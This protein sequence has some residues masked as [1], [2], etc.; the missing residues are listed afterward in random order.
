MA[1]DIQRSLTIATSIKEA[2]E[3][4]FKVGA[5]STYLAGG[6]EV[7]RLNSLV[8]ATDL[9]SIGRIPELDGILKDGDSIKI[10]AMST[11]QDIIDSPLTPC[12]LKQ[13]CYFMASRTK[14]NM[15]T[16]GGNLAISRTDSYLCPSLL[17]CGAKLEL[18]N[19]KGEVVTRCLRCYLNHKEEYQNHLILS[20][21]VPA[22]S[23]VV[24]KR[25]SNTAQSHA[26]LT[27][28]LGCVTCNCCKDHQEN[29]SGCNLDAEAHTISATSSTPTS[30][31]LILAVAAKNTALTT[32]DDI[33]DAIT[34]AM[35][36]KKELSDNEILKMVKTNEKLD[37]KEDI[38][39]SPEY[40]AYLLSVT[41]ADL[42]KTLADANDQACKGIGGAK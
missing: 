20:I 34:Q 27:V 24:S 14:R 28:S 6:T 2:A 30:C 19:E 21:T 5:S 12:Y 3:L 25:F 11:F 15:A 36:N 4:K 42:S 13:A 41:I 10:G 40:K 22:N 37:F 1:K 35:E 18:M 31:K 39:G 9:I 7:N 23:T 38:F 17:A 29:N 32:L 8:D 33:A 26:V 16:I